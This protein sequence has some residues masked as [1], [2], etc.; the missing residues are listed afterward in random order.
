VNQPRP[1]LGAEARV[2]PPG[3]IVRA[4]R[5]RRYLAVRGLAGHPRFDVVLLRRRRAELSGGDVHD[6]VRDLERL[7]DVFL[8]LEEKLVLAP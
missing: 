4:V 8:P 2:Q 7:K 3:L 1:G 5:R 6:A